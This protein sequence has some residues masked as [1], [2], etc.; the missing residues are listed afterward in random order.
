MI[1]K[2]ANQLQFVRTN[3]PM[4]TVEIDVDS[5]PSDHSGYGRFVEQALADVAER[6]PSL[7]ATVYVYE[8]PSINF[9]D[10]SESAFFGV[11]GDKRVL[12]ALYAVFSSVRGLKARYSDSILASQAICQYHL[13]DERVWRPLEEGTWY[14]G[15]GDD[16]DGEQAVDDGPARRDYVGAQVTTTASPKARI[17]AAAR[18]PG[19]SRK[20]DWDKVFDLLGHYGISPDTIVCPRARNSLLTVAATEP[21]PEACERLLRLGADPAFG[22]TVGARSV[23]TMM[24]WLRSKPWGSKHRKIVEL[25]A[26][27]TVNH[28][29]SDGRTAL[30]F[31]SVGAGLFGMKRGNPQIIDLL[32]RHGADP[33]IKNR[34]GRTALMEA[35]ES[36]DRSATSANGDVIELLESH[37]INYAAKQWFIRE[38]RVVFSDDGDMTIVPRKESGQPRAIRQDALV[39]TATKKMEDRFGLPAGSVALVDGKGKILRDHDTIGMLR[40]RHN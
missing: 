15:E 7:R 39:G 40:K 12:A 31:A 18:G 20:G 24:V 5:I 1:K 9:G 22:G 27:D 23:L 16:E 21:A 36:N 2:S 4:A 33:S 17:F 13:E 8:G 32:M 35:V 11:A 19:Q 3:S 38:Q 37:S 34:W 25:L 14:A 26:L 10:D 30:M 28:Q 29:D 6:L